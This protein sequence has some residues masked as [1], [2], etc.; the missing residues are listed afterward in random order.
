M[1]DSVRLFHSF[2]IFQFC[3]PCQALRIRLSERCG[4]ARRRV[5]DGDDEEGPRQVRGHPPH[6]RGGARDPPALGAQGGPQAPRVGCLSWGNLPRVLRG[7]KTLYIQL[8]V[9][10]SV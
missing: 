8:N 2:S 6:G 3:H 5:Q 7:A 4:P 10:D 1:L 9:I